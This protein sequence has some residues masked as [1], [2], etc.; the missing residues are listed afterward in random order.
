MAAEQLPLSLCPEQ[1][2]TQDDGDVAGRHLINLA[3]LSQL[4][5]KLHQIPATQ[6][7]PFFVSNP[8][9]LH[10]KVGL[11]HI[12]CEPKIITFDLWNSAQVCV[13]PWQK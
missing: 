13:C 1:I 12:S 10:F 4:R 5:Q 11:S 2:G 8:K 7:G 9:L 6:P 3:V